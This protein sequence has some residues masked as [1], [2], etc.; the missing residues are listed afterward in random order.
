M[1]LSGQV[2]QMF[3]AAADRLKSFYEGQ[4]PY[5]PVD[6]PGGLRR[7]GNV[8]NFVPALSDVAEVGVGIGVLAGEVSQAANLVVDKTTAA[9]AAADRAEG[10]KDDHHAR[11]APDPRTRLDR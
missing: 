6:N 8:V 5:D 4:R 9:L 2:K 3:D 7:G 1:P 10:R 11:L